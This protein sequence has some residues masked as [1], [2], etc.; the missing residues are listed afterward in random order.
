[1]K[2]RSV[3]VGRQQRHRSN[4]NNDINRQLTWFK[5]ILIEKTYC[6]EN[7]YNTDKPKRCSRKAQVNGCFDSDRFSCDI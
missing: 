1:M 4:K 3:S 5:H 6:N 2:T 7:R